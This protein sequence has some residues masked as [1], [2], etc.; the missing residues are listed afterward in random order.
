FAWSSPALACGLVMVS[1]VVSR[2][3]RASYSEAEPRDFSLCANLHTGLLFCFQYFLWR[4][5]AP[6]D[7]IRP[8]FA[9]VG[10]VLYGLQPL[11]R[12]QEPCVGREGR[13]GL[14]LQLCRGI[15]FDLVFPDRSLDRPTEG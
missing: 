5:S 7:C 8:P 15:I 4:P 3:H 10:D 9:S 6:A 1:G 13:T 14:V 11:F 2:I 12:L